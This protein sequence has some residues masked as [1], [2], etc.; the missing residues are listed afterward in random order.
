MRTCLYRDRLLAELQ[1]QER[2]LS[3]RFDQV[4]LSE[5]Q[6]R[7]ALV[8]LQSAQEQLQELHRQLEANQSSLHSSQSDLLEATAR[9]TEV[10]DQKVQL[11]SE[12]KQSEAR[13][14]KHE[15]D[16]VELKTKL[17]V[18]LRKEKELKAQLE[19]CEAVV[20]EHVRSREVE[21]VRQQDERQEATEVRQKLAVLDIRTRALKQKEVDLRVRESDV[22]ANEQRVKGLLAAYLQRAKVVEQ[23]I[24]MERVKLAQERND[25]NAT[26]AQLE[27]SPSVLSLSRHST[28][29]SRS[30]SNRDNVANSSLNHTQNDVSSHGRDRSANVNGHGGKNSDLEMIDREYRFDESLGSNIS[31]LEMS[32]ASAFGADYEDTPANSAGNPKL[33]F[34]N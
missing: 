2:S 28:R 21:R 1:S 16:I 11:E 20:Q 29:L 26:R 17:E 19:T 18:F 14:A 9:L 4:T 15:Q 13:G 33:S 12:L 31:R 7:T 3:L 30:Y 10:T 5:Q 27:Q 23:D 25:L 22:K 8:Q 6:D 24:S 32:V 34:L